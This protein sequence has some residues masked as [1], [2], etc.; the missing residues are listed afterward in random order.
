MHTVH[1]KEMH[2]RKQGFLQVNMFWFQ[3]YAWHTMML[4]T[5]HFYMSIYVLSTP[6]Q[7]FLKP[8]IIFSPFLNKIWIIFT[9]PHENAQQWK[10]NSTL[11]KACIVLVVYDGWYYH[12]I[13]ENLHFR[14]ST[15]KRE[16]SIFKNLRSG[17]L[18]W[19]PVFWCPKTAFARGFWMLKLVKKS[20]FSQITG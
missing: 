3:S 15:C 16:T 9:C 12:I 17:D 14:Q 19:E 8:E 1:D 10:Y 2:K 18:Y 7:I 6:I 11:F 4:M 20:L 5:C 13:F